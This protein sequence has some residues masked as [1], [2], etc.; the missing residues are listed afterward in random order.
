M[1]PEAELP[2]TGINRPSLCSQPKGICP[3][4]Q[5]SGLP[6][7]QIPKSSGWFPFLGTIW[8]I[9]HSWAASLC[10]LFAWAVVSSVQPWWKRS[11]TPTASVRAH[12]RTQEKEVWNCAF[13][14]FRLTCRAWWWQALTTIR[15][16]FTRRGMEK[17]KDMNI[18]FE[19]KYWKLEK[20]LWGRGRGLVL[21]M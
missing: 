4:F 11:C 17:T 19:S 10:A 5:N 7:T 14:P 9:S 16:V 15:T 13:Q 2:L 8:G 3:S 21:L 18:P 12:K 6:T 20:D 1:L